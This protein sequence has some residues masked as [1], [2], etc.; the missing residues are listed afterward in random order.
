M[1]RAVQ[2]CGVAKVALAQAEAQLKARQEQRNSDGAWLKEHSFA[3]MLAL[4][5]DEI[6][7]DL[8]DYAAALKNLRALTN[9]AALLTAGANELSAERETSEQKLGKIADQYNN[10]EVELATASTAIDPQQRGRLESRRDALTLGNS[11]LQSAKGAAEMAATAADAVAQEERERNQQLESVRTAEDEIADAT[12][13]IPVMEGQLEEVRR[14]QKLSEAAESDQAAVFRMKLVRG[15][16]CPVCGSTDHHLAEV[17]LRL[18]ARAEQ[19]RQRVSE[20]EKV[21][22]GLNAKRY[23]AEAQRSA[24]TVA[25]STA[26]Q[27]QAE[28]QRQFD[29]AHLQWQQART[30]LLHQCSRCNLAAP[31][32]PSDVPLRRLDSIISFETELQHAS[33]C[34]ATELRILSAGEAEV[35]SK[36]AQ[37][38]EL[39][40]K[41]DSATQLVAGLKE[42]EN[43]A[44]REVAALEVTVEEKQNAVG[45]LRDRIHGVL[46]THCQDWEERAQRQG[47]RFT[48]WCRQEAD[49]WQACK[50]RVEIANTELQGLSSVQAASRA[51]LQEKAQAVVSGE[52]G[53]D[54]ARAELNATKLEREGVIGGRDHLAVRTEY[55]RASEDAEKSSGAAEE[56]CRSR[57]QEHV[58]AQTNF[59][60]ATVELRAEDVESRRAE[61]ACADSLERQGITMAEAEEA[62]GRNEAWIAGEQ[63][64]LDQLAAS[65]T[66]ANSTVAERQR[67]LSTH[68]AAGVPSQAQE[69]ISRALEEIATGIENLNTDLVTQKARLRSDDEAR[70]RIALL[71]LQ[72]EAQTKRTALW[73]RLNELIGSA[74]G[75][76]FR[77]FAQSLTFDQLIRFAN[78]H[79]TEFRPRYEL[80]RAPGS[81]LGL[82]AVDHDMADEIRAVHSLSGGE[83]FL[84]SLALALGLASMSS[85]R[86]IR[87]ESLFIDE[88]FGSLDGNS[89]GV[90]ISALERLQ[91]SGRRIGIISHVEELKE[92]ISVRVEVSPEGGGLSA[93]RVVTG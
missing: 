39:R 88:G 66:I 51:T 21:L 15:K 20:K 48:A 13:Q 14:S 10:L 35:R 86:G 90:A 24:A 22:A 7:K 91:A 5:V 9:K 76:K 53:R 70:E 38:D 85:N 12:A 41:F 1:Q 60:H 46:S 6:V 30:S 68:E 49:G 45:V 72:H 75:A 4:R 11:A 33:K 92:R 79:L 69:D 77:R 18:K 43:K 61:A 17:D 62:L 42:R 58:T 73:A 93:V 74:D 37:R 31:E 52:K 8:G 19:D 81:D 83:R 50:Q 82:Q 64:R 3:E 67:A 65:V 23:R 55:R 63:S 71:K 56:A 36:S 2:D 25:S 87:V 40:T 47:G 44:K 84:A 16:P 26:E 34:V 57:A 80:Q 89:L 59:D 78:Q 27:K 54:D 28:W 29:A 32:L